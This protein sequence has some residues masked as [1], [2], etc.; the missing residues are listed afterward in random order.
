MGNLEAEVLGTSDH[1]EEEAPGVDVHS[2]WGR[3]HQ[4]LHVMTLP[5]KREDG[6]VVLRIEQLQLLRSQFL[7]SDIVPSTQEWEA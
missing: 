5:V 2:S 4:V 3:S 7:E 1:K 6:R